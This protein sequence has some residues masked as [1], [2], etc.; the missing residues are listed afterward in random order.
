MLEDQGGI[1]GGIG[2]RKK[3]GLFPRG[4]VPISVGSCRFAR[5]GMSAFYRCTTELTDVFSDTGTTHY[6]S[7]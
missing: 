1:A 7:Y 2:A 3:N 5:V 4:F 6:C